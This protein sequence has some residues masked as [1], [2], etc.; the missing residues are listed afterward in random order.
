MVHS[1]PAS[2]SLNNNETRDMLGC[3]QAW[4]PEP[5]IVH[6]GGGKVYLSRPIVGS[7]ESCDGAV[8]LVDSWEF[9]YVLFNKLDSQ[10]YW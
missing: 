6:K 2:V 7:D 8:Q 3:T 5:V 9:L 10:S 1:F 4:K